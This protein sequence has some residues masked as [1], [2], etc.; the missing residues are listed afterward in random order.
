MGAGQ[1]RVL[2]CAWD[3]RKRAAGLCSALRKL[4]WETVRPT[5]RN[6]CPSGGGTRH[7]RNLGVEGTQAPGAWQEAESLLHTIKEQCRDWA[8]NLGKQSTKV[9]LV[10]CLQTMNELSKRNCP[11]HP[12][13]PKGRMGAKWIEVTGIS[14]S[15]WLK[16]SLPQ[17]CWAASQGVLWAPEEFLWLEMLREM[18]HPQIS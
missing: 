9:R 16:K 18:G 8:P 1:S 17:C 15:L 7:P 2:P 12:P 13:A 11:P 14:F 3:S 10:S 6:K 4:L 5:A